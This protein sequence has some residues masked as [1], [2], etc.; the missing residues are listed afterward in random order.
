MKQ[1][2]GHYTLGLDIGIGSVGWGLIDD[3]QKIID[4][5][6]RIFPEAD[7]SNNDGR[8]THRST[9]RLLR[10]R[11]HRIKRIK[12][13][14]KEF[15]I[16][17]SLEDITYKKNETPYH[18]RVRG[19]NQKLTNNELATA[20]IHIGKRRGIHNV[21]VEEDGN[22]SDNEL[23]TR[24][25]IK[26]NEKKLKEQFVCEL[27]LE[28][29][30]E[31]GKVRGHENR[32]KTSDYV[33]EAKQLLKTQSKYFSEINYLFI[34]KYI[35]LIS[36]RR[37]YYEGPG[38]GSDYGW[39][40]DIKNWYEQMMGQCSYYPEELRAVKESYSAQLFNILNDLNNIVIMRPENEKL[41]QKEKED[42]VYNIFMKYRKVTLSRI[43]K[44]IGLGEHDIKGYRVDT[45]GKPLFTELKIYH[46]V[47]KITSRDTILL[48]TDT[49]DN[50]AEITTIY[51]SKEDI[52]EELLHLNLPL[53]NE[54]IDELSNLNYQ[55][56]H[57]LSLKLIKK[58][59]PDLWSSSKNQ[60]QLF[61]EMGIKPK[62]VELSGRK[63]IPYDHIDEWI[64][65]PVVKRSFKQSLRVVNEIMKNYGVPKEIVIELAREKNSNDK[66]RFLNQLNKK[67]AAL[68]RQ[69]EEKL[70]SK[71]INSSKGLFNMLRLWHLQDGVCLYSLD[72]IKIEDLLENPHN[73]EI[74]HIIPR[75]VSFDDSQ[76]NKVL[77]RK[78][79]NQNKENMTPFQYFQ[80]SKTSVSYEKFKAHVLQLANSK[81]KIP[82]KKLHY[83]LEE[84]DINKFDV[85]KEFINR[86]LVDTRYATRE[87]LTLLTSFFQENEQEVKVKSINGSFTNYLRKL[88]H[89]KKDRG[90]DF[91]HHAEDALIV[92][93]A[94]YIFENK[95]VFRTQN[96]I[97]AEE[98]VIDTETGE[99]LNESNFNATFTDKYYKIQAIKN[100]SDFKYS[101]KI[102]MKPNRQLMN[103]TLYSTRKKDGTEY[104]IEKLK[105]LYDKDND[106]LVKLIRK[107]PEKLLMYH[108][109]HQTFNQIKQIIEQY[110]E[111]KNPLWKFRE[112]EKEYVRKYS[113]K[114]NGPIIKSI[115]YYGSQLKEHHDMS[116]KYQ[117]RDKS[118]VNLSLKPFRMDVFYDE[119]IYKFVTVRYNDLIENKDG[120]VV[121]K[122]L[123]NEKLKQKEIKDIKNFEFSV[124]KNQICEINGEEY[125]LI[126]VNH[127][128]GN[129]IE[130]NNVTNDYKEF[131]KRNDIK[132]NRIYKGISKNTSSFKKISTDVLGNRFINEN[133]RLKFFYPK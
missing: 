23:S 15:E 13:L 104:V 57:A 114:G 131:C 84:R 116:H 4:A 11:S 5:G 108:H 81:E 53:S 8:R 92:A 36:T 64:L 58:V 61:T 1:Y 127:D 118:V 124:Y 120:Y 66:K 72:S 10:R 24:E 132:T 12:Y 82:K 87:L 56:T 96:I 45:S 109:D 47:K 41:S 77:V 79:E 42:I 73:Y 16:I 123:Y 112:E 86:N 55:K 99:V 69:V 83:L 27:Q 18:I 122:A 44:R 63:Y 97:L 78:K 6:T 95:E 51:Q 113:K 49:L 25:Q 40:Q 89:F 2:N 98:K 19:L 67:N 37:E 50:I 26:R 28:R 35:T 105:N 68:N 65:S 43:A 30:D 17:N 101:H 31:Q 111:A 75:S 88:W 106:K 70:E 9:R 117:P 133:E 121:K 74:D 90:V 119:G 14:L 107:S 93:M 128:L 85:Q 3:E 52:K 59:L 20:L 129:R 39:G 38:F 29:L 22:E 48:D 32:F 62:K 115:K 94:S 76:N 125:R 71:N 130:L 100:Y 126:G 60:M 7:V 80:S 34:E 110:G 21:E 46:D 103:N 91:K 54:E 33:K 102:D